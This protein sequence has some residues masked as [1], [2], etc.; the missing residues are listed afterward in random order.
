LNTSR[1]GVITPAKNQ[2]FF[3]AVASHLR[4]IPL[5][6]LSDFEQEAQR[7]S[8]KFVEKAGGNTDVMSVF[9]DLLQN[10]TTPILARQFA[11]IGFAFFCAWRGST[12]LFV[13]DCIMVPKHRWQRLALL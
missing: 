12:Q 11:T 10:R 6:A 8:K 7:I 4:R 1:I 9:G 13:S 3:G 5:L 2:R